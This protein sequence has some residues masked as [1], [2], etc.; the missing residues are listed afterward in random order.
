[1]PAEPS[2]GAPPCHPSS[3]AP[4]SHVAAGSTGAAGVVG[5]MGIISGAVAVPVGPD[6]STRLSIAAGAMSGA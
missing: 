3:V 2:A 1:M 4:Y 6:G 5:G